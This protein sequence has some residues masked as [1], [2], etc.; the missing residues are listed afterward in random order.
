MSSRRQDGILAFC[1]LT[2]SEVS[3]IVDPVHTGWVPH[4]ISKHEQKKALS[5]HEGCEVM[6]HTK[7]V[8]Q[9]A[10]ANTRLAASEN[11][12]GISISTFLPSCP[13][14]TNRSFS[15]GFLNGLQCIYKLQ[16][17][18]RVSL[19]LNSSFLFLMTLEA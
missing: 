7:E 4:E 19:P 6:Q 18:Y 10:Q 14:S 12:E 2:Q 11:P 5:L 1:L 3:I 13:T 17:I 8:G 16:K 15:A 9:M